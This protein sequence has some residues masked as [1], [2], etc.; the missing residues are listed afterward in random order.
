MGQKART[1]IAIPSSYALVILS[2]TFFFGK[3]PHETGHKD[4]W[5]S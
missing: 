1:Q 3:H 5:Q 4:N 2:L